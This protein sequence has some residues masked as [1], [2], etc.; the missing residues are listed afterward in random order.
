MTK[1][2]LL[3]FAL[4]EKEIDVVEQELTPLLHRHCPG[5]PACD[6]VS[7]LRKNPWIP[8]DPATDE[9]PFNS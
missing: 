1:S 4:I 3:V 6:E 8:K 7:G 9:H 5:R 2:L